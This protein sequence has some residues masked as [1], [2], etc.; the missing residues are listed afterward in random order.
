M[1]RAELAASARSR[2]WSPQ[3]REDAKDDE[4]LGAPLAMQASADGATDLAQHALSPSGIDK[5]KAERLGRRIA[6]ELSAR[7]SAREVQT[8]KHTFLPPAY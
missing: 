4:P 7:D 8:N 1:T 3:T 5:L 2:Y 6:A